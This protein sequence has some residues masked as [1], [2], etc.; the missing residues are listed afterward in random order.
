MIAYAMANGLQ[1]L[2][3][4]FGVLTMCAGFMGYWYWR[5]LKTS[6]DL[7]HATTQ[8][9]ELPDKGMLSALMLNLITVNA[10]ETCTYDDPYPHQRIGF[11]VVGNGNKVIVDVRGRQLQAINYWDTG[12]MPWDMNVVLSGASCNQYSFI[13]FGIKPGDPLHGLD[14][15]K[16]ASGVQFEETNTFSD[17]YY[18][19]GSSKLNIQG[20]F[21]KDPPGDLFGG[22]FMKK[23]QVI[24]KT[25][26]SETQVSVKLPTENKL[27]QINMFTEPSLS[28]NVPATGPFTNLTSIWLGVKSKEE[29][30]LN[31]YNASQFARMI[32]QLYGRL[33]ETKIR[34]RTGTASDKFIDTMIYERIDSMAVSSQGATDYGITLHNLMMWERI[35]K[36]NGYSAGGGGTNVNIYL[37]NQ[38]ILYH[39]HIPILLQDPES[40]EEDWLDAGE[41]ADV[42]VEFSEAASTGNIYIVLDELQKTYPA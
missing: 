7:D 28:S 4:L 42:Y 17:S 19:A 20:L 31:N 3:I 9:F 18:T 8:R 12:K 25:A 39:G 37:K 36:P 40:P 14:L 10:T 2:S 22:G 33:P 34:C 6:W 13:P 23:R 21:Y 30:L 35:E 16:F 15:S 29:Y 24:N 38:G 1:A 41:L 27:R 32:H 5:P 26:A 11:R